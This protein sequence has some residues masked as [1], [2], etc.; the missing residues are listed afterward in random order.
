MKGSYAALHVMY[1]IILFF[2]FFNDLASLF[3]LKKIKVVGRNRI[4]LY[5]QTNITYKVGV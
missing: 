4:K 3:I 2:I 1:G 5:P